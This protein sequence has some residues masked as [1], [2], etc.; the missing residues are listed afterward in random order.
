MFPESHRYFHV[1]YSTDQSWEF[2]LPMYWWL[3]YWIEGYL[4]FLFQT[5]QSLIQIETFMLLLLAVIF[6]LFM[7][8]HYKLIGKSKTMLAKMIFVLNVIACNYHFFI[9][10]F[11]FFPSFFSWLSLSMVASH[12][13]SYR[14]RL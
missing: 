11:R 3:K 10:W 1:N 4:S 14:I 6:G 8:F 5:F 13:V 12:F 7:L 2:H 9:K